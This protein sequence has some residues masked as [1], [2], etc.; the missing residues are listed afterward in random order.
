MASQPRPALAGL[1]F[2]PYAG[3]ADIP[4]VVAI[5]NGEWTHDGLPARVT[6]GE[7]LAEYGQASDSFDPARDITIAEL[8]GAPVGYAIRGW[9]D[10][11]DSELREYRVDGAVLPA[12]RGRGIGRALLGES[13]TR[14]AE[15]AGGHDTARARAYGSI[16]HAGQPADEALLRSEGFA[17]VRYFF[18]MGRP[19]LDDVPEVPLPAGIEV[20]EVTAADTPAIF[21]ADVEA[22]RDHWG[23][24][25]DSPAELQRWMESPEFDPRLWVVAFDTA[26]GEIAG[27]VVNAIYAEENEALGKQR[28]WLDSVFTRRPW[29]GRG[30]ARALI[31]RSLVKLRG[32]GMTSAVLG[33]DA[34]NP[35]GAL[36]LYESV[37][38]A[39]EHR[40]TAWRKPFEVERLD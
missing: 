30:L 31:S 21:A 28:F 22:F 6:E 16:S 17:P 37:G 29:R 39:V 8:D 23:G 38:F 13:M 4:T 33:V 36:G 5:I 7:K 11:N 15:L 3:P 2:R 40:Q 32:H 27:A 1:S 26:S 14:A 10:A 9:V 20:R 19:T 18:D 35:T 34:D 25:D 24:F 12:W